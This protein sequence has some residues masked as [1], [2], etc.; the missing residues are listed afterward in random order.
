MSRG[1]QYSSPSLGT[2]SHASPF[3]F[4]PCGRVHAE[5]SYALRSFCNVLSLCLS[6]FFLLSFSGDAQEP[7]LEFLLSVGHES[8][9][10][11][12]AS[13]VSAMKVRVGKGSMFK[14]V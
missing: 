10:R 9:P 13:F 4:N 8:A 12:Q 3:C 7:N 6:F 1:Q 2:P 14:H 11:S 5:N